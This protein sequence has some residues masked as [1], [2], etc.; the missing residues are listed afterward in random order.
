MRLLTHFVISDICEN[1]YYPLI[2]C[3]LSSLVPHLQPL[4]LSYVF[5]DSALFNHVRL[6]PFSVSYSFL[7]VLL[8]SFYIFAPLSSS[9]APSL[10]YTTTCLM[11]ILR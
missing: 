5:T 3:Y 2:D 1:I 10:A 7:V 8:L 11:V 9:L 6:S 4:L